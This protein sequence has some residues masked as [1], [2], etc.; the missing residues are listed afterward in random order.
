M[1]EHKIYTFKSVNLC[2]LRLNLELLKIRYFKGVNVINFN[3][4]YSVFDDLKNLE[5]LSLKNNKIKC[6]AQSRCKH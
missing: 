3:L 2:S 5:I 1:N 6:T 4:F